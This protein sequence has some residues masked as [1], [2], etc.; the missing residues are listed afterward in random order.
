M[1]MTTVVQYLPLPAR[2]RSFGNDSQVL[3]VFGISV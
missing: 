1:L 3:D 2:P